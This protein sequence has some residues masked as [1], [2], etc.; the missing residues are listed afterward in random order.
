[1]TDQA[2]LLRGLMTRPSRDESGERRSPLARSIAFASGKGGVGKSSLALNLG[3]ALAQQG[4]KVC[5]VDAATGLGN[6]D[7]LSGLNGYWNLSHVITGARTLKDIQ[8]AGPSGVTLVPGA[9]H[10][11]ETADCSLSVQQEIVEQ[12]AQLEAKH[13]IMLV[14]T[15]AAAHRS[16]REFLLAA[17]TVIVVTTPEPTSLA[18]AYS[19]LKSLSSATDLDLELVVNQAASSEQAKRIIDRIQETTRN[20]VHRTVTSSG[21]IPHDAA[22]SEAVFTQTPFVL[23]AP[24]SPAAQAVVRLARRYRNPSVIASHRHSF[25]APLCQRLSRQAG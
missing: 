13:D 8:L 24:E 11:A 7:L 4:A 6:L 18:D 15:G 3:V 9:I 5:L 14:D 25:F 17:E 1:M 23:G 16:V 2:T 20:F 21:F 22:V 19:T 10:L 12:L